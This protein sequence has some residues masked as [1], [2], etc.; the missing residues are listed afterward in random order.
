MVNGQGSSVIWG[1]WDGLV[2]NTQDLDSIIC[3]GIDTNEFSFD[4]PSGRIEERQIKK[5]VQE[6]EDGEE[7]FIEAEAGVPLGRISE[8]AARNGLTG[9]GFLV[10][11][12]GNVGGGVLMNAG[13]DSSDMRDIIEGVRVIRPDG[14][15]EYISNEACGPHNMITALDVEGLNFQNKFTK[16]QNTKATVY[17]AIFKLKKGM[18]GEIQ[19]GM[20]DFQLLRRE[21]PKLPSVGSMF[22]RRRYEKEEEIVHYEPGDYL[23]PISYTGKEERCSCNLDEL[24]EPVCL[25]MSSNEGNVWIPDSPGFSSWFVTERTGKLVGHEK[26]KKQVS[27]ATLYEIAQL[28]YRAGQVVLE[29]AGTPLNFAVKFCGLTKSGESLHNIMC[30]LI[31]GRIKPEDVKDE[32]LIGGKYL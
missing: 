9:A 20:A 21:E 18:Q 3:I 12:P 4:E 17:S 2:I 29:K 23:K 32:L 6:I 27:K 11:I 22:L 19:K 14:G 1:N 24:L 7:I 15:V 16:L 25:G 28:V 13:T 5:K 30:L 31:G 8:L 26:R 10:G